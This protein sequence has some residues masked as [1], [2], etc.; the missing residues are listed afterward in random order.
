[1]RYAKKEGC[2]KNERRYSEIQ[3]HNKSFTKWKKTSICSIKNKHYISLKWEW[4]SNN[5][6]S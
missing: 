5:V 2:K 4:S 1:M 3:D 6:Y